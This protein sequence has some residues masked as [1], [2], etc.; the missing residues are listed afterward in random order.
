MAKVNVAWLEREIKTQKWWI[1]AHGGSLGGYVEHYGSK[2]DADHYGDG[3]EAIYAAD[4]AALTRLIAQHAN[5]C[6]NA[7]KSRGS[8][9]GHIAA[10]LHGA[11]PPKRTGALG[12]PGVAAWTTWHNVVTA[13]AETLS[14]DDVERFQ[15]ACGIE[16]RAER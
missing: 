9:L 10:V 4:T 2:D 7:W 1:E 6:N 14:P 12:E 11:R 3:G 13:F 8:T 5:A 16:G 15:A